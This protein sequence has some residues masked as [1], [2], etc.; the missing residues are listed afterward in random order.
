MTGPIFTLFLYSQAKLKRE[1]LVYFLENRATTEGRAV[2]IVSLLRAFSNKDI[3]LE[4]AE[5]IA[6]NIIICV[7]KSRS[8]VNLSR[9]KCSKMY[10]DMKN[11][12]RYLARQRV[13]ALLS[14]I[15]TFATLYLLVFIGYLIERVRFPPWALPLSEQIILIIFGFVGWILSFPQYLVWLSTKVEYHNHRNAK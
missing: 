13:K 10:L 3:S 14:L 6:K 4:L 2:P 15:G 12:N 1:I 7:D 11:L 5:F 9:L 8:M